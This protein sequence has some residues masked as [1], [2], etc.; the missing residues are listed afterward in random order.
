MLPARSLGPE[1][2]WRS[3]L[4]IAIYSGLLL[5]GVPSWAGSADAGSS[6]VTVHDTFDL[7]TAEDPQ[8]SPDGTLVAFVR[9]YD[10]VQTDRHLSNIWLAS[11]DGKSVRALTSGSY[12]D[13]APRWS[14][15]GDDLVFTSNRDQPRQIYRY[16]LADGELTRVTH[17][18]RAPHNVSWSPD[19][20]SLAYVALVPSPPP[21]FSNISKAPTGAQWADPPR[22]YDQ[23]RY[24]WDQLGYLEHGM[25][26]VFVISLHGGEARQVSDGEFPNGGLMLSDSPQPLTGPA[27]PVW[28]PDGRYLYLSTVRRSDYEYHAFDTE[29]FRMAVDSGAVRQLTDRRGPDSWPTL[30]PDGQH[31]AYIGYDDH[32]LGYQVTQLY[33]MNSD[34]SGSRS[35]TASLD[36]D[37]SDIS[38]AAD[39]KSVYCVV[40]DEG[41]SQLVRVRLDGKIEPLA[42][43]L[44]A[45]PTAYPSGGYSLAPDGTFAYTATSPER[46]GRIRVGKAG[47][48]RPHRVIVDVNAGIF[49]NRR[50][51]RVEEIRYKSALDQ[52]L[53]EGWVVYPLDFDPRRKYPLIL[54]IHGGPFM[55]YGARYDLKMQTFAARGFVVLYVN[56]RGSTSYGTAFG[57]LIHH[58]YPGGDYYD[59]ESGVDALLARGF[60]DEQKLFVTGG[61]G[62]GILSAWVIGKTNR[63]RAAAILY[64][65]VNHTSWVL[66]SDKAFKLTKYF[67]ARPPWEDF[68]SYMSRSPLALAANVST[69]TVIMTGE[70]DYRTP[71]SEA[72]QLYAAL[73]LRKVEAMLLRYSGESHGLAR[74]PSHRISTVEHTLSWFDM[75]MD[76]RH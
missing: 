16:R 69:P 40:V 27:A 19:G 49:D 33:V 62:G 74:W 45:T 26:Q 28:S 54:E 48:H 32:L 13:L 56:P 66:T 9:H 29:I 24:R 41:D 5:A 3:T 2:A 55:N 63:Y 1:R 23:L 34:G 39:G 70:E 51:G 20:K 12:Q 52:R 72:E 37:V 4:R 42:R 46:F 11:A 36:R 43:G 58:A 64:P 17:S 61:S 14:P 30:S 15:S 67:F 7:A 75:H 76:Q 71:A 68:N 10:D 25:L 35:L 73:K 65:A 6:L 31:I 44:G 60:V 50:S 8:L 57:N 21:E 47:S 59:L 53:I 18:E 22:V 38:W